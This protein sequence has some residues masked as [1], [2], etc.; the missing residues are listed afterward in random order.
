MID[1]KT[2]TYQ[3]RF[4]LDGPGEVILDGF[5]SLYGLVERNLF[6]DLMKTLPIND[7]K[8]EYILKYGITA[9]QFNACKVSIEGKMD[10]IK[11][12][13]KVRVEGLKEK[14][15]SLEKKLPKIKNTK[16]IH[17]KKRSF[18]FALEGKSFFISSF[19]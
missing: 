17:Q 7:V 1:L 13:R 3:T 4:G 14:I 19:I 9:R 18:L 11:S 16:I 10:S 12:G 2:F 5:A 6:C 8:R 15:S